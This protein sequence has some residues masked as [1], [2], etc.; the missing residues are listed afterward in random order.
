MYFGNCL[1]FFLGQHNDARMNLAIAFTAIRQQACMANHTEVV[2]LLKE[3]DATGQPRVVGAVVR[4]KETGIAFF[5]TE[6]KMITFLNFSRLK[7]FLVGMR[8]LV[9]VVPVW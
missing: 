6:F 7:G 5:K 2:K 4:D 9:K 3:A 1:C 8:H